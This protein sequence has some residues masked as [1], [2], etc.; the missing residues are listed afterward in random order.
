MT[1]WMVLKKIIIKYFLNKKLNQLNII[2]ILYF[3]S[4]CFNSLSK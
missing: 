4:N 1:I 3:G 2:Y